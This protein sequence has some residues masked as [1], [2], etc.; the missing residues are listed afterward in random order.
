MLPAPLP[1]DETA[2]LDE[3]RRL[4][5]LDTPPEERFDR[6]TRLASQ[7]LRVPIAY[8]ALIDDDRQWFK[9][10]C[11][12]TA[13]ETGR[14]ISFCGHAIMND[15]PLVVPDTRDDDRFRDNPLVTGEPHLRF[16]IGHPLKGPQGHNVG[17]LCVADSQPCEPR[18][19]DLRTLRELAALTERELNLLDV[20]DAQQQL[21][22][23]Q[24]A[25]IQSRQKLAEEVE[26]AAAYVQSLLPERLSDE[27]GTDW[28]FV[29]S[30]RLGG[31]L[32]G[33]HWIDTQHLAVYLFDV[34]GHGVGA[35]LLSVSVFDSLSRQS[36]R[37]TDF[38][39]PG[40]VLA[41]LNEAFP[42][43]K[44]GDRFFTIWYGVYD[45]VNRRLRYSN[46]GHPPAVLFAR[47]QRPLLLQESSLMIGV[48]PDATFGE[49]TARIEPGTRLY[50]FSDG[51]FEAECADGEHLGLDGLV[52]LIAAA[53][54]RHDSRVQQ[55]WDEIRR[56]QGRDEPADDFSLLEVEFH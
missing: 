27:V 9:S 20:I 51:A 56:W 11:G 19:A 54:D 48:V 33:Y 14:E 46:A 32:F 49:S 40:H 39:R 34:C 31:D 26:A 4:H 10:K 44:H 53:Q 52:D 28:S 45:V 12:L 21:L 3:L 5:L 8:I 55:V 25:L 42:M 15:E 1:V 22:D 7:V 41:E 24:R 17:T 30:S 50:L 23:T 43:E 6:I 13:D 35:S 2:R 29:S 16:Y 47:E 18:E 36:L 38:E 37:G